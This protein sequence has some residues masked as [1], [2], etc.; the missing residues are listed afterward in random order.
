MQQMREKFFLMQ[1][2]TPQIPTPCYLGG[3]KKKSAKKSISGEKTSDLE[4]IWRQIR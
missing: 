1:T 3:V 2:E 4:R